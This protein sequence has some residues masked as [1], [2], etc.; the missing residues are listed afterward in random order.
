MQ[1]ACRT[2]HPDLKD[3]EVWVMAQRLLFLKKQA[4]KHP[5]AD[6]TPRCSFILGGTHKQKDFEDYKNL[7]LQSSNR[8]T[9]VDQ[10]E[11]E[12]TVKIPTPVDGTVT[13]KCSWEDLLDYYDHQSQLGHRTSVTTRLESTKE[14]FKNKLFGT[15]SQ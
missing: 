15:N 11:V 14:F 4:V 2:L 1:A 9:E 6:R 7:V 10:V 12:I 8:L 5:L 13:I 3:M